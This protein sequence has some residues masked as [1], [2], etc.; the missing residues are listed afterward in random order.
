MVEILLDLNKCSIRF[1]SQVEGALVATRYANRHACLFTKMMCIAKNEALRYRKGNYDG[2]LRISE[3][4]REELFWWKN[5]LWGMSAPIV[6]SNPDLVIYTDASLDGW[7]V[8]IPTRNVRF[9]GRWL[10][11]EKDNY[12]N[13]L[14]LLAILYGLQ[15]G[16]REE[17]PCH[18]QIMSDNTTAVAGITK[19][20]STMSLP[21]NE[22]ARRIWMW[23]W[24]KNI[25]LTAAHIPGIY[26]VE[27][28]K[29]SR[30]FRE[31]REWALTPNVFDKIF[32]DSLS[33]KLTCSLLEQTKKLIDSFHGYRIQMQ[34]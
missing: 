9:G 13:Y 12:I 23:A 19:Q 14:E 5:N 22:I 4:V 17:P 15:G 31:D 16:C 25:W 2:N 29:E 20:G 32:K 33:W 18:I 8:S 6:P 1:L 11:E 27:A 21:C 28:D 10:E 26:N 3:D 30:V 7:G 34:K 24:N